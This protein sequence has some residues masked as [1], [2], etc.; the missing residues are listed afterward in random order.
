MML[1]EA[2]GPGWVIIAVGVAFGLA[3]VVSTWRLIVGPT[4]ADRVVA[5]DLIGFIA[6]ALLCLFAI[7]SGGDSLLAIALVAALILFLGTASFA[8]YIERRGGR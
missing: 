3:A 5:I 4:L 1:A 6:I 8:V 7:A 2:N